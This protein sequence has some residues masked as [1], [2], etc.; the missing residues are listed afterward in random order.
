MRGS[1]GT[2]PG[3]ARCTPWPR[4]ARN[5]AGLSSSWSMLY[6]TEG[7]A[8]ERTYPAARVLLPCPAWA[9][10]ITSFLSSHVLSL[11][12]SRSRSRMV[13]GA[14]GRT[15]VIFMP[16]LL[17]GSLTFLRSDREESLIGRL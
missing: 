13:G 4:E 15:L 8:R 11:L 3:Y 10:M 14:G 6:Q 9:W 1:F 5:T 17:I 16:R 7:G 12:M 2:W